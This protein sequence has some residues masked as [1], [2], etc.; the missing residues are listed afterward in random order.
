MVGNC[1]FFGFL[2]WGCSILVY[3]Q[4][5]I[6]SMGGMGKKGKNKTSKKGVKSCRN[7]QK[8]DKVKQKRALLCKKYAEI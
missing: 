2:L 6:G 4:M 8:F 5:L 3:K 1:S 7:L